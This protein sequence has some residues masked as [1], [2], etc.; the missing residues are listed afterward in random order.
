MSRIQFDPV[1]LTRMSAADEFYRLQLQARQ[2]A[3]NAIFA[4]QNASRPFSYYFAGFPDPRKN[5]Y[6]G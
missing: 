1:T 3:T 5:P 6:V 4:A 2:Q